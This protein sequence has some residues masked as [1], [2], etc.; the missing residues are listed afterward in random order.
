MLFLPKDTEMEKLSE[1]FQ[2]LLSKPTTRNQTL[3]LF[4]H[5]RNTGENTINI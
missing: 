1:F 4:I 2:A 3:S 5:T